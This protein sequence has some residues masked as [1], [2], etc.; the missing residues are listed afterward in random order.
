MHTPPSLQK[1]VNEF[2]IE[3]N[4]I[5]IRPSGVKMVSHKKKK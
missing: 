2:Y 3:S 1:T 4:G 5:E